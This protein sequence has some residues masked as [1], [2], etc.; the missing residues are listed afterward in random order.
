MQLHQRPDN[1]VVLPGPLAYQRLRHRRTDLR[2]HRRLD[3]RQPHDLSRGP[4]VPSDRAQVSRAKVTFFTGLVATVAG[5]FPAIAM[6][7]LDFVAIYGL[8]LM[9]MG[10]VI[11]VDFWLSRRLGF[12]PAYAERAGV[13]VYGSGPDAHRGRR[14]RGL[15]AGRRWAGL[16]RQLAGRLIAALSYTLPAARW[17]SRSPTCDR[18]HAGRVERS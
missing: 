3:H 4:G 11:F 12:E 7:L 13:S 9:P 14:V 16:F 6:K 17:S 1:T 18:C 15:V 10:A 2:G 5:M 8:L